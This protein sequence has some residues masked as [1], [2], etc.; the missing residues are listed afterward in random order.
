MNKGGTK[1]DALKW[2]TGD[3]ILLVKKDIWIKQGRL[4]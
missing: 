1:R 3:N 4:N 2:G